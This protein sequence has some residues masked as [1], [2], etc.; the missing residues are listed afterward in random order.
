MSFDK[1]IIF[2]EF[3]VA[4]SGLSFYDKNYI[5]RCKLLNVVCTREQQ[6][7]IYTYDM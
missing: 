6:I 1:R 5:G 2:S 3:I 4:V 7:N